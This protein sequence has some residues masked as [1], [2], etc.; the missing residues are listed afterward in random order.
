MFKL[1]DGHLQV[2]EL[3]RRLDRYVRHRRCVRTCATLCRVVGY[4]VFGY[5]LTT[6][7]LW[8]TL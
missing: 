5:I 2:V 3:E 4:V 7:L 1:N 8:W 6:L